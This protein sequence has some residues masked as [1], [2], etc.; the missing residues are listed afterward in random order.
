MRGV[1]WLNFNLISRDEY[2][3]ISR[4]VIIRIGFTVFWFLAALF[5]F[6]GAIESKNWMIQN[7]E[8]FFLIIGV[9]NIFETYM[10][11]QREKQTEI[12]K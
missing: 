4:K 9:V 1:M 5:L 6:L 10:L 8:W 3:R 12:D 2:M 11:Y 7:G